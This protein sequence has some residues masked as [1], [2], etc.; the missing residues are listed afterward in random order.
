MFLCCMYPQIAFIIDED[1]FVAGAGLLVCLLQTYRKFRS[2]EIKFI[3]YGPSQN[4]RVS[5]KSV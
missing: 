1:K 2:G 3:E 5:Q 4:R